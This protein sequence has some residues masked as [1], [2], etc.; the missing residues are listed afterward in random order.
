M[1]LQFHLFLFHFLCKIED[2]L[3]QEIVVIVRIIF[4][5]VVKEGS[6]VKILEILE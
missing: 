1:K 4:S 3:K 5:S 6:R 2:L